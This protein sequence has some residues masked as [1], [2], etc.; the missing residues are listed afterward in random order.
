V[1]L[2][3]SGNVETGRPSQRWGALQYTKL[4]NFYWQYLE[5]RWIVEFHRQQTANSKPAS[6]NAEFAVILKISPNIL[7]LFLCRQK[8]K[9]I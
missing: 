5:V 6:V 3:L 8:R 9:T 4:S 1:A 7:W 2:H